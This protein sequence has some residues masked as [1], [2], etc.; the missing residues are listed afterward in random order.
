MDKS[1]NQLTLLIL[2]IVI[3]GGIISSLVGHPEHRRL[4][5]YVA[6]L[7]LFHTLEFLFASYFHPKTTNYHGTK[8]KASSSIK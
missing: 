2:G 6:A 8:M 1:R 5:V 7:G 3:G 4:G